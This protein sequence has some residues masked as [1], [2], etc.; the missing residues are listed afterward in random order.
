MKR[1][2]IIWAA[3]CIAVGL[4]SPVMASG[5]ETPVLAPG[6]TAIV[7]V[8]YPNQKIG[9]KAIISFEAQLLETNFGKG[10]HVMKVTREDIDRLTAAGLEVVP[11]DA[12]ETT[13]PEPADK[14]AGDEDEGGIP[15]YPCYRTVE[16]T[17]ATAEQIVKRNRKLAR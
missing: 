16:E 17:F 6:E 15:R 8:Y 2:A 5:G 13:Q 4:L 12:R 1:W 7:R 10:Y 3:V 14:A 11:A 9:N